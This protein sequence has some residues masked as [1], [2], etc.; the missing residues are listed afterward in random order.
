METKFLDG[1]FEVK[2]L[3]RHRRENTI[4]MDFKET[5]YED[6]DSYESGLAF[7]GNLF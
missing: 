1:K 6:L 5:W 3:Q 7:S 2:R 4:K